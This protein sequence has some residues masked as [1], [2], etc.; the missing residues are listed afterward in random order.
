MLILEIF[1]DQVQFKFSNPHIGPNTCDVKT[2]GQIKASCSI[3]RGSIATATYHVS[4]L[5]QSNENNYC[6][7]L[8]NFGGEQTKAIREKLRC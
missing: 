3:S 1:R 5:V 6:D 8:N 4:P 7:I 2:F